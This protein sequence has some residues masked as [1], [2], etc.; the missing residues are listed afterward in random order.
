[1]RKAAVLRD[2]QKSQQSHLTNSNSNNNKNISS[3]P[4]RKLLAIW[5]AVKDLLQ[6]PKYA[7]PLLLNVTGSVWF[8]LLIGQAGMLLFFLSLFLFFFFVSSSVV[9]LSFFLSAAVSLLRQTQGKTKVFLF[10][11]DKTEITTDDGKFGTE[12]S[13]T[14]PIT[15]SLAFLF[16]VLGEWW[17]DGKVISRGK[18]HTYLHIRYL[19]YF[20][21]ID[22]SA[23]QEEV[24]VDC[25]TFVRH[26][27]YL[28]LHDVFAMMRAVQAATG[29]E[30]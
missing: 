5:Y 16:T 20:P 4:Q 11:L 12:L 19:P 22:V 23:G 14:V 27:R 15:N 7:I 1:M 9:A 21:Y 26:L 18:L 8:F 25:K 6:N 2:S 24:E 28:T 30:D 17:A 10:S 13:L 3:W 29:D